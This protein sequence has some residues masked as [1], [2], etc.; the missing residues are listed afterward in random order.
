MAQL[1]QRPCTAVHDRWHCGTQAIVISCPHVLTPQTKTLENG[2]VRVFA[3]PKKMPHLAPVGWYMLF[4][5][6][7]RDTYSEGVWV[8]LVA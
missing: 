7:Q 4:L 3:P 6:G 8:Q 5:L 1:L 2:V